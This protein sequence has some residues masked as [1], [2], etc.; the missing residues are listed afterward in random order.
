M[1][2]LAQ[3]WFVTALNA[4]DSWTDLARVHT[5]AFGPLSSN[6]LF[7]TISTSFWG[8]RYTGF[9][10]LVVKCQGYYGSF[11]FSST[12]SFYKGVFLKLYFWFFPLYF[13][14]LLQTV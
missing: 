12:V 13:N 6:F 2:A 7:F 3:Q 11:S 1:L 14:S 9:G 4:D 5:Q 8:G 10:V